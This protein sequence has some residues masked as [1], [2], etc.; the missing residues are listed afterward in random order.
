MAPALLPGSASA[1][2]DG[3]TLKVGLI[4]CGGRGTGA[5]GQA[6]AADKNVALTAMADVFDDKLKASL[7]TLRQQA[8]DKVKVG[9]DRCFTGLDAYQKLIDSGVDVVLLATPPGF[10]P[11]HL[12]AAVAAGKHIFCE[13]P[14]ATDAPGVRSVLETV[15]EAR[16]KSL[17]LVAGFCWRYN[18]AE[19]A[20]FQRVHDGEVGEVRAVYATY[21][22]GG[23]RPMPPAGDR[24]AT[25][26]DLEW[27]LHNWYNFGWLSGDSLVEQAVHAVDWILWALNDQTPEKA[28][29]TGGR[30]IPGNGGNIFDHFAV[31]YEFPGGARGFLGSRQQAGC[32]NDNTATI[33]GTKGDGRELGFSGMPF[34]RGENPWKYAG[35]RPNMYQVEHDEL[36]A[37]IRSGQPINNGV[38]MA[39]TTLAA[40]MG[41]MAAYTGQE[42]TWDMALN[43][44]EALVPAVLDWKTPIPV[45]SW[46]MPGRTKFV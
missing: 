11:V 13:K 32:A 39:N 29:A 16:R 17:T 42:I 31:N 36:F 2:E 26:S 20:L 40:I 19:R 6:L 25:M 3:P 7:E 23:V 37:S 24:P 15:E 12:K 43:S 21:Y 14:V 10:R 33:L 41:R 18:L 45:P 5:A 46:A 9:P 34:I 8:P 4:G 30:Q 38:R 27:Q 35:P 44:Q 28:V 1:A 22:T